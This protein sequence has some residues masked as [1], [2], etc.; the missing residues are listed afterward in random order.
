MKRVYTI[1]VQCVQVVYS[2]RGLGFM[3]RFVFYV[4]DKKTG[5]LAWLD[6]QANASAAI[7]QVLETHIARQ[8]GEPETQPLDTEAIRQVLREELALVSFTNGASGPVVAEGDESPDVAQGMDA[9][10]AAWAGDDE[11]EE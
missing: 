6:R 4:S 1:C 10:T 9:L 8:A 5:L 11:E 2:I 3:K 7:V